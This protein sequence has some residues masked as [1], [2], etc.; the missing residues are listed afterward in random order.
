MIFY[1]TVELVSDS[2]LVYALI[3]L[4]NFLREI[5][6]QLY[7]GILRRKVCLPE[8]Y[9]ILPNNVKKSNNIDLKKKFIEKSLEGKSARQTE[10]QR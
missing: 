2:R 1:G 10:R 7:G 3:V 5:F 9:E 6:T 8:K 4:V